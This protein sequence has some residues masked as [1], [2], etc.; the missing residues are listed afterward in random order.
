MLKETDEL[1]TIRI[2]LKQQLDTEIK[3]GDKFEEVVDKQQKQMRRKCC[4]L[5]KLERTYESDC[6]KLELDLQL[7]QNERDR[8]KEQHDQQTTAMQLLQQKLIDSQTLCKQREEEIAMHQRILRIRS[9]LISALRRKGDSNRCRM[10]DLYAEVGKKSTIVSKMDFEI[11][12]REEEMH[13]LFSTLSTKQMEVSRQDQLIKM[14][15]EC[16]AH[17]L[18]IR[19]RQFE[20]ISRLEKEN[21]DLKR[22]LMVDGEITM[23]EADISSRPTALTPSTPGSID[24]AFNRAMFCEERQ[25]KR[26]EM[27]NIIKPKSNARLGRDHR[28]DDSKFTLTQL[29]QRH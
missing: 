24:M 10:V 8:L 19:Q 6:K 13:N 18:R 16:N 25:K 9:E 7:S 23:A 12:A 3:R 4:V 27:S 22:Q 5:Q 29:R 20:R 28:G 17:N 26:R 2:K 1:N 21:G 15:E 14:L 11:N